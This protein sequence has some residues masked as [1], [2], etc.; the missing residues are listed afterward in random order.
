MQK[1]TTRGC[2]THAVQHNAHVCRSA[3]IGGPPWTFENFNSLKKSQRRVRLARLFEPLRLLCGCGRR[4]CCCRCLVV[5]KVV[6]VPCGCHDLSGALPQLP[7]SK[8]MWR[9]DG[10]NTVL[11][12]QCVCRMMLTHLCSDMMDANLWPFVHFVEAE[13][14][15]EKLLSISEPQQS[16]CSKQRGPCPSSSIVTQP[17]SQES[18]L[19]KLAEQPVRHVLMHAQMRTWTA[20]I[21]VDIGMKQ[22]TRT[23][24]L[25]CTVHSATNTLDNVSVF[26]KS[27]GVPMGCSSSRKVSPIHFH[28]SLQLQHTGCLSTVYFLQGTTLPCV[29]TGVLP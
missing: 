7:V 21:E 27:S 29:Q 6:V 18:K 2:Q 20:H 17:P 13:S 11:D 1:Q 26:T 10:N 16:T 19:T 4:S 22:A 15:G 25:S 24:V 23:N 8:K 9:K 5:C 3:S 14:S 28:S 12:L